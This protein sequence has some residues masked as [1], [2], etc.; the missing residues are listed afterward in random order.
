MLSSGGIERWDSS[1]MN[2]LQENL[3]NV[4][5]DSSRI[6]VL[7]NVHHRI[8][9]VVIRSGD[10]DRYHLLPVRSSASEKGR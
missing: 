3:F 6:N 8:V 5:D 2:P 4:M 10:L 9:P 1:H 7:D